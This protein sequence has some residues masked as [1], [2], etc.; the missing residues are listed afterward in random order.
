MKVKDPVC[1]MVVDTDRAPAQG[2][3]SGKTVY[4]CSESC[5][6]SYERSHRAG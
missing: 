5:R 1:N 4:F 6:A 2:T 3:Y